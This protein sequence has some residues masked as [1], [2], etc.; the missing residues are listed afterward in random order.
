MK[1]EKLKQFNEERSHPQIVYKLTE[2]KDT[3]IYYYKRYG[4]IFY[5]QSGKILSNKELS[6]DSETLLGDTS[7]GYYQLEKIVLDKN[8]NKV[9]WNGLG[10]WSFKEFEVAEENKVFQV[11][12]GVLYTKKGYDRSGLTNKKKMIELV[13][14]P[15]AI[16]SHNI[17]YGT[18]RIANCA[19]KGSCISHLSIPNSVEEI[20]IN[21]FYFA[22][23][24]KTI[25]IPLSLK[26][27]EQQRSRT[28]LTIKYDSKVFYSWKA[29]IEYLLKNGFKFRN[30]NVLK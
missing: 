2:Y 16:N 13:A 23:N 20:G 10:R 18:K 27:L 30:N 4:L 9:I 14:C 29:L 17:P 21:A 1:L 24:L 15:T 8:V 12:D 28:P 7:E 3:P 6:D 19:F 11:K 22:D 26:K 25:E 5:R